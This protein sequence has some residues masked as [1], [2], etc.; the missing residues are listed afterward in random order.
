M[1]VAIDYTIPF[2]QVVRLIREAGFEVISLGAR[3][4]HSEYHTAGGRRRVR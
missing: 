2:A 3:T 1:C 4:E